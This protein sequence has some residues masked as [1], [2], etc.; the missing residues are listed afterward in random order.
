MRHFDRIQRVI[1]I[2]H[3]VA[4]SMLSLIRSSLAPL[5]LTCILP[6][7][8][9]AQTAFTNVNDLAPEPLTF[10]AWSTSWVD[11]DGDGLEDVFLGST[12]GG[13]Y[14]LRNT[15]TGFEHPVDT[16]LADGPSMFGHTWADFD[17][18]GDLDL[19]TAGHTSRLFVNQGD[20]SFS[21]VTDRVIGAG[22]ANAGWSAAWGDY[23]NDGLVDLVIANPVGF[24]GGN[25][26]RLFHNEG[27]GVFIG[28]TDGP[29]VDGTDTYTIPTWSD[30]DMDGDIDLFIGSGPANGERD[31]NFL[32]RNDLFP[33]GSAGFERITGLNISDDVGDGQVM[34][35]IDF[36]S[37][38]DFDLCVT[39]Y[40]GRGDE[41]TSENPN[42]LSLPPRMYRNN[43][44]G[45]FDRV[46]SSFTRE[47]TGQDLANVWGD[48]DNDG[49]LDVLIVTSRVTA[50]SGEERLYFNNGDGSFVRAT[51]GE[52]ATAHTT[53]SGGAFGDYDNDGDLDL[54]VSGISP[55]TPQNR[56]FRNEL[57]NGNGWLKL[58]LVGTASNAAAIGAVVVAT[59][60][61]GGEVTSQA[62]EV[63]AQNTFG[64][65]NSLV[66]HFGLGDAAVIDEL[67]LRWPSGREDRFERVLPNQDVVVVEG[68]PFGGLVVATDKPL[69]EA[70]AYRLLGSYP[71]PASSN[72]SIQ[73][74]SPRPGIVKVEVI[75]ALGR[76]VLSPAERR[77]ASAKLV[78]IP[79]DTSPLPA[80]VYF[81]VVKETSATPTVVGR[82]RLVVSR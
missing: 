78:E 1:R 57:S 61:V 11:Y 53:S 63:S 72:T 42:M 26:N 66:V 44:D 52:L 45:T 70:T 48:V 79:V 56:I 80:G 76:V 39:N 9:A 40:F 38:G 23:D 30:F 15:G 65:Q 34:N 27:G 41:S 58:R 19:F 25:P 18:D 35:W 60:R 7:A 16:G 8:G 77:V 64:G 21:M 82:G 74:E 36:D 6:V 47:S 3:R 62:R 71:N 31:T 49:D 2:H 14:L 69:M 29:V 54:I 17:N 20:G 10:P 4:V 32:Y 55:N 81:F 28:I 5:L 59:A 50:E 37:D 51:E 68:E 24:V 46:A 73:L 43:G 13:G 22:A 12:S 67:F 33:S 75:D